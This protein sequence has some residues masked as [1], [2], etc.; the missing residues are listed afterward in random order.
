MRRVV[1]SPYRKTEDEGAHF[2]VCLQGP[3]LVS[4]FH[5]RIVPTS[6]IGR[7]VIGALFENFSE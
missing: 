6:S 2:N 4:R 5:K 3:N 7:A 1:L